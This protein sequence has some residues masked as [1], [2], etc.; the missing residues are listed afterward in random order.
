MDDHFFDHAAWP[1]GI[2]GAAVP[3]TFAPHLSV[4]SLGAR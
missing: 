3:R 4:R 1:R 2:T